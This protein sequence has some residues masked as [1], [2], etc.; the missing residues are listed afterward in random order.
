MRGT[1]ILG[2]DQLEK[3]IMMKKK[4]L[5]PTEKDTSTEPHQTLLMQSA[6][7]SWSVNKHSNFLQ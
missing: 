6:D 3:L 1:V 7:S 5:S 4:G 2:F